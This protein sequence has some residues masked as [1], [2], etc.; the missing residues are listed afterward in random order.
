MI[1]KLFRQ[2]CFKSSKHDI[3]DLVK[4][5]A[6]KNFLF[7]SCHDDNNGVSE[8]GF[9]RKSLLLILN[10]VCCYFVLRRKRQTK[11]MIHVK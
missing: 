2:R 4:V 5:T 11:I 1:L 3:I 7:V 10:I 9:D 8:R 6:K